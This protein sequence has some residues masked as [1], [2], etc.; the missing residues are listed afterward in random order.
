MAARARSHDV[1]EC[2]LRGSS[3]E[4]GRTAHGHLEDDTACLIG[5]FDLHGSRRRS[6]ACELP[7]TSECF[8][9]CRMKI[10]QF[11]AFFIFDEASLVS[12]VKI[13]D[14]HRILVSAHRLRFRIARTIRQP[15]ISCYELDGLDRR[16]PR[17]PG[18]PAPIVMEIAT[19]QLANWPISPSLP[20]RLARFAKDIGQ[21]SAAA[22]KAGRACPDGRLEAAAGSALASRCRKTQTP[23]GP[24]IR[25]SMFWQPFEH[26]RQFAAFASLSTTGPR[27]VR[28]GPP[29]KRIRGIDRTA[30]P[31]CARGMPG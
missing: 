25:P 31:A 11:D 2:P 10:R 28:S 8:L 23:A 7:H 29:E 20:R 27:M 26:G 9:I 17:S 24:V 16:L 14:A 1:E 21:T 30:H 18:G 5:N 13:V 6:I 15:N 19:R 12:D 22:A 3:R 4:P